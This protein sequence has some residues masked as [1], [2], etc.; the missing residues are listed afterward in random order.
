MVTA[1]WMTLLRNRLKYES[2]I[3]CSSSHSAT[4]HFIL[5]IS[6]NFFDQAIPSHDI[7]FKKHR[8]LHSKVTFLSLSPSNSVLLL[9]KHVIQFLVYT[10]EDILCRPANILMSHLKKCKQ[11]H[12]I[13]TFYIS[14]FSLSTIIARPHIST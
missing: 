4:V 3:N 5:I 11:K 14:P 12:K 6:K 8:R 7:K 2:L 13:H 10:S 1:R 9:K